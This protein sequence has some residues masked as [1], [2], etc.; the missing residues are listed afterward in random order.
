MYTECPAVYSRSPSR[1]QTSKRRDSGTLNAITSNCTL[2]TC[3]TSLKSFS[4]L[5]KTTQK[6]DRNYCSKYTGPTLKVAWG[7]RYSMAITP[8]SVQPFRKFLKT[9]DIKFII[10]QSCLLNLTIGITNSSDI[11]LSPNLSSNRSFLLL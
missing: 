8:I 11:T 4:W 5:P 1:S 6:T 9:I 2:L 7:I 3:P 10:N